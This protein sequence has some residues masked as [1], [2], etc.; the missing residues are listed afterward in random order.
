MA[1]CS[2]TGSLAA[3]KIP[4][5]AL[6]KHLG[7]LVLPSVVLPMSAETISAWCRQVSASSSTSGLLQLRVSFGLLVLGLGVLAT[8][9]AVVIFLYL[10]CNANIRAGVPRY[11]VVM[12][13][14]LLCSS[15][16]GIPAFLAYMQALTNYFQ[17]AGGFSTAD[18]LRLIGINFFWF[19]VFAPMYPWFAVLNCIAKLIVLH[20]FFATFLGNSANPRDVPPSQPSRVLH[21]AFRA[22]LA[23]VALL[24]CGSIV[25]WSVSSSHAVAASKFFLLAASNMSDSASIDQATY[26][27]SLLN[28]AQSYGNH[29][30]SSYLLLIS[31]TYVI[32]GFLGARRLHKYKCMLED[33]QAEQLSLS[34]PVRQR[35]K[36]VAA[37]IGLRRMNSIVSTTSLFIFIS[38]VIN[39]TYAIIYSVADAGVYSSTC[40]TLC[41][42]S[43]QVPAAMLNHV[44]RL[45]PALTSSVLLLSLV[46][47]PLLALA[48]IM[49]GKIWYILTHRALPLQA[50]TRAIQLTL[51]APESRTPS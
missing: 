51:V 47:A 46:L 38:Y 34:A 27:F 39:A 42:A 31:A 28:E 48:N 30:E 22:F 18:D 9:C 24:F 37:L 32:V 17:A 7:R 29:I 8:I 41:D 2:C 49:R 16:V 5:R 45:T 21:T 43:C 35:F 20:L 6:E 40:P 26:E 1:H 25:S 14:C 50:G 3:R 10:R 15:L 19:S 4:Q 33:M 23:L 11:F 13:A 12:V 36:L 44:L